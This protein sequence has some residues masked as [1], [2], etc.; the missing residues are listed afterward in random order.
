M[1]PPPQKEAVQSKAVSPAAKGKAADGYNADKEEDDVEPELSPSV[2][3]PWVQQPAIG[4]G[5]DQKEA[6]TAEVVSP[7]PAPKPIVS[8]EAEQKKCEES[9]EVSTAETAADA[10]EIPAL[11]VA[12]VSK[13]EDPPQETHEVMDVD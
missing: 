5:G 7:A 12:S 1:V 13:K 3:L 4:L 9:V 2:P 6:E 10:K 11:K 8:V